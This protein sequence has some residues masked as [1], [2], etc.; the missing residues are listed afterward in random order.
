ML[1]LRQQGDERMSDK[2]TGQKLQKLR[3]LLTAEEKVPKITVLQQNVAGSFDDQL[4]DS[5]YCY[6]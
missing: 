3:Q 2:N 5:W 6:S 4:N 1:R